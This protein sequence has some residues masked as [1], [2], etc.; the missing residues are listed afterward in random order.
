MSSGALCHVHRSSPAHTLRHDG[1]QGVSEHHVW[2]SHE[3]LSACSQPYMLGLQAS[4]VQLQA[5]WTA[6]LMLCLIMGSKWVGEHL[7]MLAGG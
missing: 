3:Q 5:V 6:Q 7:E 2:I 1:G 4:P